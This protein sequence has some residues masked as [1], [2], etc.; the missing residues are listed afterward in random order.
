MLEKNV[1]AMVRGLREHPNDSQYLSVTLAEIKR[2][3]ASMNLNV[4]TNAFLKLGYLSML[5]IDLT[6]AQMP[7][8]EVMSSASFLLKRPAMFVASLAF[9]DSTELTLLT[10]NIFSKEL[11][12]PNVYEVSA[13]LSCLSAIVTQDVADGVV[14]TLVLLATH[15]KPIVRKKTAIAM[16]R[17]CEK[18]P[19]RFPTVLPKLKDLLTDADQSVQSAAVASFL[20]FGKRNSKLA[21]P[22][23]PIFFHLLKEIKN[24]WIVIKLLRLMMFLCNAESR[25]WQKL[26]SSNVLVD[27]ISQTKAK[28]VQVEF[29]RFVLTVAPLAG[30]PENESE[31]SVIETATKFLFEFLESG[32]MN[33]RAIA[34]GIACAY[35]RGHL[36]DA[37]I[38]ESL[39]HLTVK[40]VDST[41]PTLRKSAL[42]T[43]SLLADTSESAV[44]VIQQLLALFTKFDG[45]K[46]VQLEVVNALL[47]I[48]ESEGL[49]ADIEWYLRILVLLGSDSCIDEKTGEILTRQFKQM[50]MRKDAQV[51]I[52]IALAALRKDQVPPALSG[53][54]AWTV[55]ELCLDHWSDELVECCYLTTVML[56]KAGNANATPE[57]KIDLIWGLIRIAI[58]YNLKNPNAGREFIA[59]VLEAVERFAHMHAG[60]IALNE[61]CAIGIGA[62]Q[63]AL[64]EAATEAEI[65]NV[66]F[67]NPRESKQV[68]IPDGLN[69][70]F[71]EL[72]ASLKIDPS[73]LSGLET[74]TGEGYTDTEEEESPGVT[75]HD[76]GDMFSINSVLRR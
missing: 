69:E 60:S 32:D 66:L 34:L 11:R 30:D 33:I 2:E 35:L 20:E 15:S 76:G 14:D 49:I 57:A 8:I 59:N 10:T 68:P 71:I 52:S 25:L 45:K 58:V 7:I 50:A 46:I 73:T 16:F 24:N 54:C 23:I 12:S 19:Q 6:I 65:K 21:V 39:F 3:L 38:R 28:S 26:V 51:G 9:K 64:S 13:A 62:L 40:A 56:R 18:S 61:V 41:D 70:P 36:K 22:L 5:G 44:N 72:P 27:L 63:W 42:E 47:R 48:G 1:A 31:K 4:K 17:I 43:L 37:K 53:A 55:A 67:A 74:D 75:T 29:C